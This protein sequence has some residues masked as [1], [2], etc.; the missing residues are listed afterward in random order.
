MK[1][2]TIISFLAILLLLSFASTV[3]ARPR[4]GFHTGPYLLFE[5]GALQADFDTDAVTGEQVGH[6]FD[7]TFG[8]LFG[9]N[10]WDE[11][12]TELQGRYG[13]N[14]RAGRREHIASGNIYAKYTFIINALTDFPTLRILPFLKAGMASQISVLPAN[15]DSTNE[16]ATQIGLGP[17]PGAGIAFLWKKYFY[18]GIDIQEDFLFYDDIRETVNG[19]PDTLVYR[20]GFHP[21]FSAMAMIGVHY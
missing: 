8:F 6:D 2:R 21:S 12:S 15:R 19:V 9:W 3:S 11:F 1:H 4:R 20:G 13:T 18:F 16:T 17:S 10:L 5:I 14:L 7:A